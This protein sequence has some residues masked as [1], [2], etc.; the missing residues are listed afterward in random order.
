VH[1]AV[2]GADLHSAD[3]KQV[4]DFAKKGMGPDNLSR[5]QATPRRHTVACHEE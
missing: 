1:N 4:R 2:A 3:P 5:Q